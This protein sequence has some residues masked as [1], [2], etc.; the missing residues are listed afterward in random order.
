MSCENAD[1]SSGDTAIAME[2]A[3]ELDR[4]K[5]KNEK[6]LFV[7]I[8]RMNSSRIQRIAPIVLVHVTKVLHAIIGKAT[9]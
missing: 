2:R 5:R 8:A 9:F 4:E 6:R 1:Q 3:F 7:Q